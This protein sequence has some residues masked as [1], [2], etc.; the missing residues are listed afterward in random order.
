MRLWEKDRKTVLM[1]T[2][3]VDE[4]VFLAD[5]VVVMTNGPEAHVGAI[6]EIDLPRPRRRE[7]LLDDAR[8]YTLRAQ[9]LEYLETMP[10]HTGPE[11]VQ[12]A[13]A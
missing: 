2:H 9:L 5:R 4:A 8:F 1:V 13:L 6:V 10:G 3:D 11:P 7:H 12:L